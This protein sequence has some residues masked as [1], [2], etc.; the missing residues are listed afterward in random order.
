MGAFGADFLL[1]KQRDRLTIDKLSRQGPRMRSIFLCCTALLLTACGL[2]MS[3]EDRLDRAEE[4]LSTGDFR[5]AI[6]DAKDVLRDEPDNVRG[7]LL[8]G[9]ASIKVNDAASAEK[10]L[11]RALELGVDPADLAVDLG[12]AM[13]MLRQ[14]EKVLEEIGTDLAMSDADR[15]A[16]TQIRGDAYLGAG[17]PEQARELFSQIL[18]AEENDI[19]AQI[20]IVSSYLDER[21][22]VQARATMDHVLTTSEDLADAW[23]LSAQMYMGRK[24]AALAETHFDRALSLAVSQ[25]NDA[26]QV[27]SLIGLGD[28]LLAQSKTDSARAR[29]EEL[30]VLAPQVPAAM[31]LAARIAYIDKDWERAQT[32]LQGV[33]QLAPDYRP[34]QLLLGSVHLQ[35]GNLEQAEMYLTAVVAA[36]PNYA[37]A[38]N[39]LAQTRL[40][41]KDTVAANSLLQPMLEG[42][43]PDANSLALAAQVSAS[44]GEF[45]RALQYL[46]RRVE[47]SPNDSQA[48]LDLAATYLIAN[49]VDDAQAILSSGDFSDSGA[50]KFRRDMMVVVSLVREGDLE[51]ALVEAKSV[52]NMWPDSSQA[53]SLRAS[54]EM[55]GGDAGAARDSFLAASDLAPEDTLPLQLL[56]AVEEDDSNFTAARDAYLKVIELSPNDIGTLMAL[57]RISARSDDLDAARHWLERAVSAD[58]NNLNTRKTLGQLLLALGDFQ[59]AKDLAE[60]TISLSADNADAHRLLGH[61]QLNSNDPNAAQESFKQAITLNPNVTEYWLSLA[62]AQVIAG[63]RDSAL[64]TITDAYAENAADEQ[65]A[66]LLATTRL[67]NGD[68]DAAMIVANDLRAARPDSAVPIYLEAEVLAKKGELSQASELFD[69]VLA[70]EN[71]PRFAARA[72]QLRSAAGRSDKRDPLLNYLEQNPLNSV[73]RNFLAQGYQVDGEEES[74]IREYAKVIDIAPEDHIALN[75]LAWLFSEA[76]DARAEEYARKAYAVAPDDTSVID[77]LGWILVQKGAAKEGLDLLHP[78]AER[79]PDKPVVQYHVA[80]ALAKLGKRDEARQILEAVLRDGGSFADREEAEELL[81]QL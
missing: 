9:R 16:I 52:V 8:L 18:D 13:I 43:A 11:R 3:N 31:Q 41:Q 56:G 45:D 47:V 26:A 23:L 7:R 35:N 70:I 79:N 67:A 24:N 28:A 77:T 81:L 66:V 25:N 34:A 1:K 22:F 2:A 4:A 61:A 59:A 37:E 72:Y 73:V 49:R 80:A 54:V 32:L 42:V 55:L 57:A 19:T 29:I 63:D 46:Q 76:G 69:D 74:A 48:K 71:S 6:I 15:M 58:S 20:G 10:E 30:K 27:Q 14:Y 62:R 64:E 60:E 53:L 40:R 78:L 51:A 68:F 75:N 12:R 39:L 65:L 21:N 5:A 36:V 50:D 33:L 44:V 17:Q 38:R